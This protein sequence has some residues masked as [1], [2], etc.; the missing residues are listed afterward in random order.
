MFDVSLVL[1]TYP[2][3][4]GGSS[5]QALPF[6]WISALYSIGHSIIS[7]DLQ[8]GFTETPVYRGMYRLLDLLHLWPLFRTVC[9]TRLD[10]VLEIRAREVF[11]LRREDARLCC[12]INDAW[13]IQALV[14]TL[15]G[16]G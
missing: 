11:E 13:A 4:W 16:V 2:P 14:R 1:G 12:S 8:H 3:T 15:S 7:S 5:A 10:D 6:P 9:P